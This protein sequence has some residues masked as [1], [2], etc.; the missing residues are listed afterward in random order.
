MR[1]FALLL[2]VAACGGAAASP[3]TNRASSTSAPPSASTIPSSDAGSRLAPIDC[4]QIADTAGSVPSR[5]LRGRTPKEHAATWTAVRFTPWGVYRPPSTALHL[6]AAESWLLVGDLDG[7][8]VALD[9]M[10]GQARWRSELA[11][12]PITVVEGRVLVTTL[13]EPAWLDLAT[14]RAIATRVLSLP[15]PG[16][17]TVGWGCPSAV[18][19]GSSCA[20]AAVALAAHERTFVAHGAETCRYQEYGP[21]AAPQWL[22]DGSAELLELR[23]GTLAPVDDAAFGASLVPAG[24][25]QGASCTNTNTVTFEGARIEP[26]GQ[27]PLEFVHTTPDGKTHVIHTTKDGVYRSH[28]SEDGRFI[29]FSKPGR[30]WKNPSGNG[31]AQLTDWAVLDIVSGN[32]T[33]LVGSMIEIDLRFVVVGKVVVV[34]RMSTERYDVAVPELAGFD[35]VTGR[36]RWHRTSRRP[37]AWEQPAG[38]TSTTPTPALPP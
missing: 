2:V 12:L 6:L 25:C 37:G 35:L 19:P 26:R 16:G 32:V 36:E 31:A 28:R 15:V 1:R 38:T 20:V 7:A 30:I 10:T 5:I 13:T 11:Q 23:D 29:A 33:W 18:A 14:G 21:V 34:H 3:S 17:C 4:R 9:P 27:S 22:C 24:A 8:L